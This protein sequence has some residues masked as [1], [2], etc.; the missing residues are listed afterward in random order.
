MDNLFQNSL[1]FYATVSSLLA[2]AATASTEEGRQAYHLQIHNM[3]KY[4]P[5]PSDMINIEQSRPE[6]IVIGSIEYG[7]VIVTPSFS[8][9]IEVQIVGVDMEDFQEVFYL[10]QYLEIEYE[11]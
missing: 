8:C 11:V 7:Q 10:Y 2:C 9:G 3:N 4:L 6:Y 5:N 1:N